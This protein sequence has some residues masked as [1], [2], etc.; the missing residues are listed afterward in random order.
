MRIFLKSPS[1]GVTLYD[2]VH[3]GDGPEFK[4]T[5]MGKSMCDKSLDAIINN[6]PV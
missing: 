6:R 3:A 5:G 1:Q 4:V 2:L